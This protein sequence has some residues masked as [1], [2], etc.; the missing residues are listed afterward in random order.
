MKHVRDVEECFDLLKKC[1]N[2]FKKLNGDSIVMLNEMQRL[3]IQIER[4]IGDN[5]E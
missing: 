5:D 3:N 1:Q 2:V 4:L